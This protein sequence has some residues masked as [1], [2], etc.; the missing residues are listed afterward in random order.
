ML[1]MLEQL[2]SETVENMRGRFVCEVTH[3]FITFE[4]VTQGAEI[5][6]VRN[7]TGQLTVIVVT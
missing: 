3:K 2:N 4:S 7:L 1:Q 5:S 6:P